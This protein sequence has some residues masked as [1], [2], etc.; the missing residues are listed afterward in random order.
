MGFTHPS[1]G[2]SLASAARVS[3][4]STPASAQNV[5]YPEI[6]NITRALVCTDRAAAAVHGKC[7]YPQEAKLQLLTHSHTRA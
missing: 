5:A 1:T 7:P 3:V 4:L 6:D 2:G